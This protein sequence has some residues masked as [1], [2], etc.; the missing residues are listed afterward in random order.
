MS[1][2][3]HSGL[4]IA[5]FLITREL[6][7]TYAAD[8][9]IH[10]AIATLAVC[11]AVVL[12]AGRFVPRASPASSK[13]GYDLVPLDENG[14]AHPSRNPST[15]PG[16]RRETNDHEEEADDP[17]PRQWRLLFLTLVLLLCLRTEL[18][19]RV[20]KNV[21][22]A[23]G[24]WAPTIPTMLATW[25][26]WRGHRSKKLRQ[27]R[28]TRVTSDDDVEAS[29][30]EALSRLVARSSLSGIVTVS[31]VG[32]GGL[33]ALN[34][35]ASPSGTYICTA[36][37]PVPLRVSFL[38]AVGPVLDAAIALCGA[39]LLSSGGRSLAS[40][41]AT[42]GWALLVSVRSSGGLLQQR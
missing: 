39:R 15:S 7:T 31:M 32:L 20:L 38:Q 23:R 35:T 3:L 6:P 26:W 18:W 2:Y 28:A 29:A 22:C 30:Y 41:F 13:S 16:S 4:V 34:S 33:L 14:H 8:K 9:P 12:V 27:R 19:H 10:T 17:G 36:G 40:R 11:G 25:E 5:T 1:D 42:I 37:L 21:Q 24:T